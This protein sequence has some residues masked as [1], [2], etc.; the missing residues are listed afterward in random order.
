MDL[1]E[2]AEAVLTRAWMNRHIKIKSIAFGVLA[3]VKS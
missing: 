1:S 2:T 3:P